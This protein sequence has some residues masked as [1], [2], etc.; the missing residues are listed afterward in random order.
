MSLYQDRRHAGRVLAEELREY[1]G[2]PDVVVLALPRGGV[3]VAYEVATRLGVPLDAFVVRKLGVPGYEEFAMGAI[4]PGGVIVL[5]SEVI[6]GVGIPKAAIERVIASEQAELARREQV[7]R[8]GRPPLDVAG[9]VVIL[10]DDGL[11]TGSTMRA[12]V[13]ALR[14]RGARRIVVG[15][16]IASPETCEE[17]SAEVDQIVCAATPKPFVAVDRWYANFEQTTDEGVR[18]LLEAA[19]REQAAR[20]QGVAPPKGERAWRP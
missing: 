14:Q 10:V 20:G 1:A 15:V 8:A 9:K 18:Q 7:Y 12:A 2:R 16:P 5:N 3:P 19:A 13:A 11:A 4:A 17:L 6:E